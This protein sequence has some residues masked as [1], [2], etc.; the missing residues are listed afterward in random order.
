MTY[1]PSHKGPSKVWFLK[2]L[3]G[4]QTLTASTS[5][6]SCRLRQVFAALQ[7]L[8]WID[9]DLA[10]K[11]NVKTTYAEKRYAEKRWQLQFEEDNNAINEIDNSFIE[12]NMLVYLWLWAKFKE[13]YHTAYCVLFC[14]DV[15]YKREVFFFFLYLFTEKLEVICFYFRSLSLQT[16]LSDA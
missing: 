7:E 9:L 12:L 11:C 1:A 15:I 8:N 2:F 3:T 14:D 16:H 10:Q 4:F 5:W 13:L 6:R